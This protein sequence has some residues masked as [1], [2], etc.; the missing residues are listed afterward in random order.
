MGGKT[1]VIVATAAAVLG[2]SA[3]AS[4]GRSRIDRTVGAY[5]R[6]GMDEVRR[7]GFVEKQI[8]IGG[9]RTNYAEG[10]DNG[11]PLLL[12]HGQGSQWQDYMR[13]LPEIS[14]RHHV[15]AI[16]VYG[17]GGSAR[18]PAAEY[19]NVR[20]GELVAQFLERVV[21]EPGIVSG[22]SSGGLIATWIAAYRPDLV[23]GVV[24]EDPPF[25]SSVMPRAAKT[26]GGDTALVTHNFLAQAQEV[27][28]PRYFIENSRI[29]SF[30][31]PLARP[32]IAYAKRYIDT[33]PGRPLEIFFMPPE[34]NI[35]L[36]GIASYDPVFGA[37]WYDNAWYEGFDTRAA[38]SA[39]TAPTVLIHANFWYR[40]FGT[41]YSKRGVLMAAM[42]DSDV[43]EATSL[44]GA[45]TQVVEV[46]SG[47]MVHFEKPELFTRTVLELASRID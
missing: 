39:I 43:A 15:Y 14:R 27:G 22:H 9:H 34:L 37:A 23:H 41:Y 20:I 30:L 7:A 6:D 10:P 24:L 13:V 5:Y 38:L 8:D 19:T 44:L 35:F 28:F 4:A 31:G 36:R 16:D 46:E 26:T 1:K 33:H 32:I 40:R 11:M 12:I 2:V 45:D 17:H 3:I 42:D 47:H 18:L 29:L 21:G 25:F